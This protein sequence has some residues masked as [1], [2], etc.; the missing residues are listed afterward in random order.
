[1]TLPCPSIARMLN[2]FLQNVRALIKTRPCRRRKQRTSPPDPPELHIE[3][4][5]VHVATRRDFASWGRVDW[6]PLAL[7]QWLGEINATAIHDTVERASFLFVAT[8]TLLNRASRPEH[9]PA[10]LFTLSP[11]LSAR[12][13]SLSLPDP[14][15][16]RP[17]PAIHPIPRSFLEASKKSGN[18]IPLR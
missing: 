12:H 4:E 14:S 10:I 7:P 3:P 18:P 8:M 2:I 17:L 9:A 16:P 1:M 13:R 6:Y 11:P 5:H 15:T